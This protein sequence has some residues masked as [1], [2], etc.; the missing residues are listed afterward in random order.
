[1]RRGGKWTGGAPGGDYALVDFRER[2]GATIKIT[3]Q[4]VASPQTSQPPSPAGTVALGRQRVTHVGFAVR[5]YDEAAK[6]LSDILEV[7]T[8]PGSTTDVVYPPGHRWN[9]NSTSLRL[10][11]MRIPENMGIELVEPIVGPNPWTEWLEKNHGNALQHIGFD[12]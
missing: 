1:E 11:N 2:F 7:P 3:R 12:A 4:T 8:V 10:A 6:A 5:N 9:P